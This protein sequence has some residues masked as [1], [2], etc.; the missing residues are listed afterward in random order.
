MC[1]FIVQIYCTVTILDLSKGPLTNC[2]ALDFITPLLCYD[3]FAFVQGSP[4][5]FYCA[6]F[7][8]ALNALWPLCTCPLGSIHH[9]LRSKWFYCAFIV[10]WPFCTWK[11][12]PLPILLCYILLHFYCAVTFLHLSKGA[13]TNLSVLDFIAHLLCYDFFALVQES[14]LPILLH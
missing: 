10:L 8:C 14:L 13:R 2:I 7:Y 6:R 11:R 5:Q 1:L 4:Y 3:L 9:H 12:V